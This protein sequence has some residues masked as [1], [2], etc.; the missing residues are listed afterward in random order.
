MRIPFTHGGTLLHVAARRNLT[1]L[2]SWLLR[3]GA[4]VNRTDILGRTALHHAVRDGAA[5]AAR[6]LIA[7]GADLDA[8]DW[9]CRTPLYLAE[10]DDDEALARVIREE[11][12]LRHGQRVKA[13][14]QALAGKAGDAG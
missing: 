2:C 3:C 6:F 7:Q 12:S 11:I 8:K 10:S 5:D 1:G 4:D 9:Q 13:V 14:H